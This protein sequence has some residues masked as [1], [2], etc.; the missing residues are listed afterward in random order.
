MS[1]N[2]VGYGTESKELMLTLAD[3]FDRTYIINL[4]ERTDRRSAILRELSVAGISV[5][6][7]RVQISSAIRSE[8]AC[9]FPSRAVRGCYMS[10]L[11]VLEDARNRKLKNVLVMED[12]L[13]ISPLLPQ[14]LPSILSGIDQ[15]DWGFIYLGHVEELAAAPK[16]RLIPYTA[17]LVTAHFYAVNGTVLDRLIGYL[18]QV[19]LRE[20]GDPDGGPMHYDGALSMFRQQNSDVL[21]LI[22]QPNLGWQRPSRSDIHAHWYE[23]VIGLRNAADLARTLRQSFRTRNLRDTQR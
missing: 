18:Q 9:G 1:S 14:F 20:P 23:R 6:D 2:V 15:Q 8:K 7:S 19:L 22:A 16:P 4:P 17:P 12:D 21:T 13:M 10:H 3:H 11:A 5:T